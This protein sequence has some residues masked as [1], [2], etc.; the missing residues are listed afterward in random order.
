MWHLFSHSPALCAVSDFPNHERLHP[1]RI[2]VRRCPAGVDRRFDSIA[3]D[4][5]ELIRL[6]Q[7]GHVFSA[8]EQR[9]FTDS[10]NRAPMRATG[11]AL[12]PEDFVEPVNDCVTHEGPDADACIDIDTDGTIK[13]W[14][15]HPSYDHLGKVAKEGVDAHEDK[16]KSQLQ[17]YLH[18][19]EPIWMSRDFK[20]LDFYLDRG[21]FE[22]PAYQA[23]IDVLQRHLDQHPEDP[24]YD[25]IVARIKDRQGQIDRYRK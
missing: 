2:S 10:I 18:R 13:T 6:A 14:Y 3:N 22:I 11:E 9:S 23:E 19:W 17:P 15:N 21:A 12:R 25:A 1:L 7:R 16:H 4:T 5:N 8:G 24:I 20:D